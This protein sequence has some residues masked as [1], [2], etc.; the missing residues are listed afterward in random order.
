MPEERNYHE[1]IGPAVG[2]R[3]AAI[4]VAGMVGPGAAESLLTWVD[5]TEAR[6]VEIV[7]LLH[8]LELEERYLEQVLDF[9]EPPKPLYGGELNLRALEPAFDVDRLICLVTLRDDGQ[10][11]AS[12]NYEG[13]EMTQLEALHEQFDAISNSVIEHG[14]AKR[15]RAN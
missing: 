7:P 6:D 14:V 2:G 9:D 8:A 15:R 1:Q 4:F 3:V 5:L 11:Y 13:V 10:V 12:R